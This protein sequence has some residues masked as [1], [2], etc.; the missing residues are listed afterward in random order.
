MV[1]CILFGGPLYAAMSAQT[2]PEIV[3]RLPNSPGLGQ[4]DNASQE[5][6]RQQERERRLRRQQE[7]AP[8]VYLREAHAVASANR[9]PAGHAVACRRP[10]GAT[11][12][13]HGAVR[14]GAGCRHASRA[15]WV[16]PTHRKGVACA[17]RRSVG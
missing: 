15:T 4:R 10:A 12:R 9:R 2:R 17:R 8:V 3:P 5:I 7:R 14:M 11:G 13:G 16:R 1:R 6:I